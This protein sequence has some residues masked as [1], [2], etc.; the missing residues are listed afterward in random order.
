[1]VGIGGDGTFFFFFAEGLASILFI[2]FFLPETKGRAFE[3]L[4]AMFKL[5]W[6]K[7]GRVGR[8]EADQRR[9]GLVSMR[10]D[11]AWAAVERKQRGQ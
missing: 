2:Y 1:M 3:E 7:I 8:I 11:E 10:D 5:P 6:Y 4:G 9:E